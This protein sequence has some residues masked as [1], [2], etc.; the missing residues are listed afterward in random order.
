[1]RTYDVAVVGLGTA[2]SAAAAACARAGLSVLGLE[3]GALSAAGARWVN[4]V[5]A[6]AFGEAGLDAPAPPERLGAGVPFHVIAG[7]GPR[8][9]TL[10]GH[11]TLEVDMRRL[12]ERLQARA[13][14]AGAELREGVRVRGVEPGGSLRVGADTA[15]AE[16]VIDAT[17][18]SGARLLGQA[19]VLPGD[20]CAAAQRVHELVDEAAAADWLGRN[21]A[22]EGDV[23]CFTG[24]AGGYSIVNVRVHDG[25]VSILTGSIPALGHESGARLLRRFVHEHPFVGPALFGGQRAIPLRPP[26][27][28]LH[29]GRVAAI[30]DA[31]DQVHPAHGSGIAQQLLAASDLAEALAAGE[32]LAGYDLRFQRRRAGRLV[33][34]DVFRRFSQTLEPSTLDAMIAE[35]VLHAGVMRDVLGQRPPRPTLRAAARSVRGAARLPEWVP[36]LA[37]VVGRM[38]AIEAIY[39]RMPRRPERRAH[40]ARALAA[41]SG[42][43]PR[44]GPAD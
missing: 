19:P 33:G 2:G 41:L 7:W 26:P 20:L 9:V 30:G 36:R 28:C 34:A 40:A 8:R 4:G 31:A 38:Q 32:G 13:A 1:M 17:G 39:A 11:D 27:L 42:R 23:V 10:T 37:S 29:D 21:E 44:L 14:D 24:V 12:V 18:L 5:P 35:G 43:S 25:T 22:A 3:A 6:W 16:V 15:R